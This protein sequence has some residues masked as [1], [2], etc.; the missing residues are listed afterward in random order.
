MR[1]SNIIFIQL[2][3]FIKN[4]H[5]LKF[6]N[7]FDINKSN[8]S[9]LFHR[10]NLI[11]KYLNSSLINKNNDIFDLL[12]NRNENNNIKIISNNNMNKINKLIILKNEDIAIS[13]NNKIIIY[14]KSNL[15]EKLNINIFKNNS[16]INNF[17]EK[18]GGGL[19]C[20]GYEYI[21]YISLSL[22]NKSYYIDNIIFEKKINLNSIIEL[23]NNY[24]VLLNNNYGLELWK[25]NL[26]IKK[27]ELND[28]YY[29][30]NNN[31]NDNYD[32]ENNILKEENNYIFK[33]NYNSFI[34]SEK[35]NIKMFK[36]NDHN[37]IEFKFELNNIKLVKGN[38]SIIKLLDEDYILLSCYEYKNNI[39]YD[40]NKYNN[41][42][43]F[44]KYSIKLIDI[45][46][47]NIIENFNNNHPFIDMS[48]YIDNL[49]IVL[50]SNG[51]IYK[52]ELDKYQKKLCLLDKIYYKSNL[53]LHNNKI[54]GIN[55]DKNKRSVIL[56]NNDKIIIISNFD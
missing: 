28:K 13:N 56:N 8:N 6:N 16:R 26:R 5:N 27:Y 54:N 40:E 49:I 17:I 36:I 48:L 34:L 31:L 21:N 30:N 44:F 22:N 20:A 46:N 35:D 25:N 55:L 50:D 47:F 7:N 37:K 3:M 32:F 38:N 4:V 18:E 45:N 23:N 15:E 39:L 42:G 24:L 52:F 41:S 2:K 33:I 19:L 10:F 43:Y 9:S 12:N 14:D 53:R 1:Q 29:L 11:F 51:I